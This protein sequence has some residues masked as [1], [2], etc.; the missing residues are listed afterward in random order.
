MTL[1]DVCGQLLERRRPG[2]RALEPENGRH[3]TRLVSDNFNIPRHSNTIRRAG[4]EPP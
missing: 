3:P 4:P 2:V 1:P